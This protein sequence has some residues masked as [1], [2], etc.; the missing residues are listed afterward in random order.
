[1][2]PSAAGGLLLLCL[3]CGTNATE[4]TS[5][6]ATEPNGEAPSVAVPESHQECSDLLNLVLTRLNTHFS[7]EKL[8][9]GSVAVGPL[10]CDGA[11]RVITNGDVVFTRSDSDADA[12]LAIQFSN[13]PA[14]IDTSHRLLFYY[15]SSGL[16]MTVPIANCRSAG[17]L[18]EDYV[19]DDSVYTIVRERST[20]RVRR[21][22][23]TV[24][25]WPGYGATLSDAPTQE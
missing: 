15:S 25:Q 23:A 10:K 3:S 17:K 12:R 21:N 7:T 2:R 5:G 6:S 13:P 24:V 14:P 22:G 20:T 9:M 18:N 11:S 4:P 16:S 19:C 8:Y 1:M